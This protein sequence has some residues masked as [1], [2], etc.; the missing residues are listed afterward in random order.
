MAEKRRVD[1]TVPSAA[2]MYDWLLDGRYHY[3]VDRR[4]GEELLRHAPTIKQLALNNRWFLERVVR[5]LVEEHGI[6]Q[7]IDFGSGLPTQN[8]VHQ[9]AQSVDKT[10]R[11][12]YVDNDP[13]VMAHGLSILDENER[14]AILSADMTK[15]DDVFAHEDFTRLID[16]D[17]PV[18][19]LY[20]S[21]FHCVPDEA[22]PKEVVRSVVERLR[23]GSFVV[24]C[25]LV[26][27]DEK[28]RR[29][30]TDLMLEQTRG[31]WGRVRERHE[32]EEF[33]EG[34]TIHPPGLVDVT[35]WR[36]VS[37]LQQR[38]RSIEITDFGGLAQVPLP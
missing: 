18:A 16:L 36:P 37:E 32:V 22:K 10:S 31:H 9:V 38:Q 34:L 12:V 15:P 23:P 4:T 26:S 14:T 3:E 25:H 2:R 1:L 35:D 7:F 24:L 30:V 28:V 13:V 20:V 17:Q 19:V 8:N 33:F 27:D 6:R 21:V 29:A 5:S 11:V